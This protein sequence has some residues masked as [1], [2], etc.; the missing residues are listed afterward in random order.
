M[1]AHLQAPP[2]NL[3][4]PP[5]GKGFARRLVDRMRRQGE[6]GNRYADAEWVPFAAWPVLDAV[7]ELVAT[8]PSAL[9]YRMHPRDA[10][11][12]LAARVGR[13]M[14]QTNAD[15]DVERCLQLLAEAGLIV[16]TEGG[17]RL[18]IDHRPGRA[19]RPLREVRRPAAKSRP[20]QK[21]S[22]ASDRKV[23]ANQHNGGKGGRPPKQ[24][25]MTFVIKGG[26]D[27]PA[28][29]AKSAGHAEPG[30]FLAETQPE[31]TVGFTEKPTVSAQ[32][33]GFAGFGGF[34]AETQTR[35]TAAEEPEISAEA[36]T[37]GETMARQFS[38][39]PQHRVEAPGIMQG[40][41]DRTYTVEQVRLVLEA[42]RGTK[43]TSA[44]MLRKP[45][46]ATFPEVAY[47]RF[48]ADEADEAAS[49][50][51]VRERT[52]P[53]S[54]AQ[55]AYH[56]GF[57]EI[58]EPMGFS[59]EMRVSINQLLQ[60]LD[61]PEPGRRARSAKFAFDQSR[62]AF[63]VVARARPELWPLVGEDPP[64]DVASTP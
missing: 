36:R 19:R 59:V 24:R 9:E 64:P 35:P 60:G 10:A 8:D 42:K 7:A 53:P 56:P 38:F 47:G 3:E 58:G 32:T 51:G 5:R 33:A 1:S 44:R 23:A 26:Q 6:L 18:G 12:G 21:I 31:P 2:A 4:M 41:L 43:A 11:R 45:L 20:A 13:Q 15:A 22:L 29:G 55:P 27:Q 25:G 63:L 37:L 52:T 49:H 54:A 16:L 50:A 48:P 62:D 34:P 28:T 39:T 61:R 14:G 40:Y 17:V 57:E 30:G 46:E